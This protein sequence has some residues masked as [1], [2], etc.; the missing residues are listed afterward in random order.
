MM[1]NAQMITGHCPMEDRSPETLFDNFL[2][3]AQEKEW[4]SAPELIVISSETGSAIKVANFFMGDEPKKI[5]ELFAKGLKKELMEIDRVFFYAEGRG[6][7]VDTRDTNSSEIQ[8]RIRKEGVQ[9][10]LEF[11]IATILSPSFC[12]TAVMER[13]G[14]EHIGS[15]WARLVKGDDVYNI[16]S[17]TGMA[18]AMIRKELGW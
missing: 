9:H 1:N 12:C 8:N 17:N 5:S 16:E 18:Y 4:D 7:I 11:K 10:K 2:L 14:N 3:D 15:E 13:S 6:E